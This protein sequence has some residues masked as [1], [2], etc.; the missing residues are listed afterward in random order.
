MILSELLSLPLF[1]NFKQINETTG[2]NNEVSGTAIFDWESREDV[3]ETFNKGEFVITTLARFKDN[4]HDKSVLDSLFAVFEQEVSAFAVKKTFS[5]QLPKDLIDYASKKSIPVFVFETTYVDDI[6]YVIKN[7]LINNS[8]NNMQLQKLNEI[9][10]TTNESRIKELSMGIN[11]YFNN[12]YIF[13]SSYIG[14]NS[15]LIMQSKNAVKDILSK[16]DLVYTLVFGEE[17]LFAIITY[18][19][20]QWDIIY[21]TVEDIKESLLTFTNQHIGV[22]SFNNNINKS[23]E[24]ILESIFAL[25]SSIISGSNFVKFNDLHGEK[26][27]YPVLFTT[28][29]IN[30]YNYVETIFNSHDK[31]YASDFKKTLLSYIKNSG[32]INNVAEELY[33]HSNTIRY[34]IK[35]IQL[36]LGINDSYEAHYMMYTYSKLNSYYKVLNEYEL[37]TKPL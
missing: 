28:K 4:N 17:N 24:A 30:Y 9:L 35:K 29:G 23:K 11:K 10:N 5:F 2:L 37:N 1:N 14:K 27:I 3:K 32:N 26:L 20:S 31:E 15:K 33:Q 6:I 19:D 18:S 34:R 22:S 8:L 12:N 36:L 13:I 7:S 21:S 25:A 16:T